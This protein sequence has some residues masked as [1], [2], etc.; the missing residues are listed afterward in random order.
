MTPYDEFKKAVL[1]KAEADRVPVAGSIELTARCNLTCGHCYINLPISDL[2]AARR[3]LTADKWCSIIDQVVDAGCLWLLFTG[4]EVFIR[5]DFP[6]IYEHAYK[7]GVLTEIFTNGTVITPEIADYLRD[8]KPLKVEITLYGATKQTYDLVTGVRGSFDRCMRGI[9]LILS[10]GIPLELKTT[11]TNVNMR[12]LAGVKALAQNL[13]VR[14]RFDP[15]LN[16]RVDGGRGP[17]KLRIS[18]EEVV[19]LNFEDS[20]RSDRLAKLCEHPWDHSTETPLKFLCSAGQSSFHIDPYG[21]LSPCLMWRMPEYGLTDGSFEEGWRSSLQERV[22][23]ERTKT[24]QCDSCDVVWLCVWCPGWGHTEHANSEMPVDF[25]CSVTR[26]MAGRLG[27]NSNREVTDEG[28]R[29]A[30][31]DQETL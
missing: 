23:A 5:P 18:P 14:F 31:A 10:R 12:E 20:V 6:R 28:I 7:K 24:V 3:E 21:A 30:E 25:L 13:G 22:C 1:K 27:L 15:L 9:G 26:T 29:Y 8:L 2:G 11:V 19:E 16:L 4:G 17:E